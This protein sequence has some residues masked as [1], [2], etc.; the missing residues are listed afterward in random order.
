MIDR[1]ALSPQETKHP[2]LQ[3]LAL[4]LAAAG[5]LLFLIPGTAGA[6]EIITVDQAVDKAMAANLS[7][8]SSRLELD[9][10][11][12]TRDTAWNVLIPK[13]SASGTLSRMNESQDMT[14]NGLQPVD[15]PSDPADGDAAGVYGWVAPYSQ[16]VE[17]SPWNFQAQLSANLTL[18]PAL[19]HGIQMTRLD[20]RSG[21][22]S[23]EKAESQLRRDVRKMFYNI[24]LFER[25]MEITRQSI[26]AAEDRYDQ[27]R[28]NYQNGLIPRYQMLSAQVALENQRPALSDQEIQYASLL[29]Q[30]K[31]LLGIPRTQEITLEGAITIDPVPWK[32]EPLI[33]KHM[34]GNLD[35]QNLENTL[36]IIKMQKALEFDNN[37][38]A[39]TIMY[40]M[41]PSLNDPFDTDWID[42]DNWSQRGGMLGITLS[43]PLDGWLPFSSTSVKIR[44]NSNTQEQTSL[45]IIQTRDQLEMQVEDIVRQMNKSLQSL[46]ARKLNEELAEESYTLAEEAY[47]AGGKELLEVQN[48]EIELQNA[49]LGVLQERLNYINQLLELEYL[50]Q[51]DR[52]TLKEC[53]HEN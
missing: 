25:S 22:I 11:R 42:E 26:A 44:N 16:E 24:L 19:I 4:A 5:A 52:N 28:I 38:P 45:G 39:L 36:E 43:V 12:R 27:A 51:T 18:T 20:Y 3:A 10:K 14:V 41:D 37:L 21:L 49:R 31:Q 1:Q 13:V 15:N 40:S 48:A 7:V 2:F 6:Q 46:E 47:Q 53:C 17:V 33:Q 29:A 23:L 9:S 30:F 50:L 8:E 32:S 35:L 34:A